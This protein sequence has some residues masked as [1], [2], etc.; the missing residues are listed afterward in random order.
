MCSDVSFYTFPPKR[1]FRMEENVSLTMSKGNKRLARDQVVF[2]A[3]AGNA[4]AS[5]RNGRKTHLGPVCMEV[6]DP[7]QVR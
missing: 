7:W 2:F 5:R 1:V 3:N 4:C 6:G